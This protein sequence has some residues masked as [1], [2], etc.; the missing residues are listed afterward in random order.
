MYH[1]FKTGCPAYY[2]NEDHPKTC[3][4]CHGTG[5][6]GYGSFA[7]SYLCSV[8]PRSGFYW[9]ACFPKGDWD[10]WSVGP[11]ETEQEAIENAQS[12]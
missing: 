9:Q 2:G 7:V 1:K 5:E 4:H 6:I 12:W 11:F 8:A 3:E 10:G